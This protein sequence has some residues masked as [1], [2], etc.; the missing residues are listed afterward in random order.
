MQSLFDYARMLGVQVEF[1]DL[2]HLRRNGDYCHE[3]KHVRIQD[4]MMQRKTRHVLAHELGHATANDVPSMLPHIHRRQEER[5]DEWAAHFL[6][7]VAEYRDAEEL[8]NGKVDAMAVELH[9]LERTVRAYQ[10]TMD[11]IGDTTYI[12][13]RL[14]IGQWLDRIE[15]A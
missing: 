9:V 14:G 11:R 10:R 1:T 12:R 4:G 6:I 7:S 13:P 5:A 3:L 8:H 2:S 15:V